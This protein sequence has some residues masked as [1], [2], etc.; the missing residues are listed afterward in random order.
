LSIRQQQVSEV[1]KKEGGPVLKDNIEMWG[2]M[3][4]GRIRKR[5]FLFFF[6]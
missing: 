1:W 6:F 2:L 5:H 4:V 3:V